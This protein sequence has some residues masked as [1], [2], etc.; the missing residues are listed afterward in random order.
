MRTLAG[1]LVLLLV[2]GCETSL[3]RDPGQARPGPQLTGRVVYQ[4][5]AALPRPGTLRVVLTRDA[6]GAVPAEQI[7]E[8]TIDVVLGVDPPFA[9]A[10]PYDRR[11]IDN[12]WA[13]S[14]R[15][16]LF[17]AGGDLRFATPRA[18]V[19]TKRAPSRDLDI[20]LAQAV[21]PPA[22]D[23]APA[24]APLPPV[25]AT[26]PPPLAAPAPVPPPALAP[27]P[28]PAASPPASPAPSAAP[29]PP[30]P[31]APPPSTPAADARRALSGLRSDRIDFRA[32]GADWILDLYPD[33]IDLS[34]ESGRRRVE[35]PRPIPIQPAWQ[36][37]IFQTRLGDQLLIITI[38]RGACQLTPTG[39]TYPAVVTVEVE[40]QLLEGCG[41][42][43]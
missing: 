41:R 42:S 38:R 34:F 25:A 18:A 36:G 9:F 12:D 30:A 29:P 16:E 17:D 19:L 28:P 33:R 37:L 8:Q 23:A 11:R 39:E 20:V 2:A 14:V 22:P 1:L 15:A 27:P 21:A 6:R 13:Y 31:S 35:A 3:P 40:G 10:I 24:P 4:E 5:L 26:R 32:L 43:V 7:A